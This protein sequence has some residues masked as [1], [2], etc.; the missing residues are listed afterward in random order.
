MTANC[1]SASAYTITEQ[2]RR[3]EGVRTP[4]AGGFV[5]QP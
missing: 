1:E 4:K 3:D 5:L 2:L